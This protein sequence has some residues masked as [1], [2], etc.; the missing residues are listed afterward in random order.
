[1]ELKSIYENIIFVPPAVSYAHNI[2]GISTINGQMTFSFH[3]MVRRGEIPSQ[4]ELEKEK[5]LL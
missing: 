3:H 2:I 1:M 5:S 4:N